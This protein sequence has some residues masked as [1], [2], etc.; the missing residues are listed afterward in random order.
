MGNG[1]QW[2]RRLCVQHPYLP[3]VVAPQFGKDVMDVILH[4]A[5]IDSQF[6]RDFLVRSPILDQLEDLALSKRERRAERS[7][8]AE[9]FH[10]PH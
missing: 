5:E 9:G 3:A 4:G 6:V 1:A 7:L 10:R 2:V 8:N